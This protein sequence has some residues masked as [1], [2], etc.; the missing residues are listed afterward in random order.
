MYD[1]A[2]GYFDTALASP[3]FSGQQNTSYFQIE[4]GNWLII[5]LDTAYYDPSFFFFAGAISDP[6]QIGFL[7]QAAASGKKIMLLT[8]HNPIDITGSSQLGLWG[9][10]TGAL[11]GQKT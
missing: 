11:G 6:G 10:V 8:H 3:L 9:Q 4:F 7:K 5:G 1:G 2:N